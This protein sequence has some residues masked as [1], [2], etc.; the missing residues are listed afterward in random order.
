MW[1]PSLALTAQIPPVVI[2]LYQLALVI[3]ACW[4]QVAA[5]E[6]RRCGGWLPSSLVSVPAPPST[7]GDVRVGDAVS[8]NYR[9]MGRWFPGRVSDARVV[10]GTLQ[11]AVLYDNGEVETGVPQMDVRRGDHAEP[12]TPVMVRSASEGKSSGGSGVGSGDLA[13]RRSFSR[14]SLVLGE[15]ELLSEP[16]TVLPH[17]GD[18][19]DVNYLGGGTWYPGIVAKEVVSDDGKVLFDIKYDDGDVERG[20]PLSDISVRRGHQS[21]AQSRAR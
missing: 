16:T 10:N 13:A 7:I 4:I 15:A 21:V 5:H 3:V 14:P 18:A 6:I 1:A 19:V 11:Y 8:A 2:I 12:V 17:V 9:G 20:V